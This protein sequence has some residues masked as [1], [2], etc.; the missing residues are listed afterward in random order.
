MTHGFNGKYYYCINHDFR[1]QIKE[2]YEKH[3][4]EEH[5]KED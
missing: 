1:S 2:Y 4:K 5:G 3:L